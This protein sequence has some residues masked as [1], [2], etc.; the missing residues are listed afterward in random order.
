MPENEQNF[1]LKNQSIHK[2]FLLKLA[3]MYHHWFILAW[4]ITL[5]LLFKQEISL[6]LV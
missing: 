5:D 3:S 1:L 6:R 2:P 4:T